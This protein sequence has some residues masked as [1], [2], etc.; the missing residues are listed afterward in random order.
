MEVGTGGV[1]GIPREEMG[2]GGGIA[3]F[4]EVGGGFQSVECGETNIAKAGDGDAE[5]QFPFECSAAVVKGLVAE[6][7]VGGYLFYYIGIE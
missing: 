2:F 5:H 4:V 3:A 7:G 1:N 6:G